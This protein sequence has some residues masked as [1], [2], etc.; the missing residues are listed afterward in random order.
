MVRR[1]ARTDDNQKEIVDALRK[2]GAE[3]TITSE[4]GKGFPD[5]VVS[6]RGKWFMIEIK[7]GDKV[8]SKQKLTPEELEWHSKQHAPTYIVN[9]V[10][11]AITLLEDK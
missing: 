5:I 4:L 2:I 1:R 8:P 3:V 11:A 10:K 9:S 6:Y 7:D